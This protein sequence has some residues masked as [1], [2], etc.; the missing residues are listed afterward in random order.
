MQMK[1]ETAGMIEMML[2]MPLRTPWV[3]SSG[4]A[5]IDAEMLET[6]RSAI[7]YIKIMNE[8]AIALPNFVT[9]L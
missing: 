6:S 8:V 1:S 7:M 5:V 4:F 3:I 9:K 2:N